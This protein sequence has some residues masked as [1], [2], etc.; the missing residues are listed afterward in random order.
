MDNDNGEDN[1]E[2]KL[3]WDSEVGTDTLLG[4]I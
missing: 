4:E 2:L 1:H 3:G